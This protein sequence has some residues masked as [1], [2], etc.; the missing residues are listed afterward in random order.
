MTPSSSEKAV[1]LVS[2]RGPVTCEL[3]LCLLLALVAMTFQLA[4]LGF[5]ISLYLR[6][7]LA[8]GHWLAL[9]IIPV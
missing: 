1:I 7:V 6:A 5:F 4:V 3:T 9:V 2:P 8:S